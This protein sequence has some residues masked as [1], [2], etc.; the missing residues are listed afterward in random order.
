MSFDKLLLRISPESLRPT[1]IALK[2]TLT[3]P[4]ILCP[5]AGAFILKWTNDYRILF[6]VSTVL[7]C[8]SLPI[9]LGLPSRYDLDTKGNDNER[10]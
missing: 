1:Y 4:I 7:C 2:G 10:F 8:A 9:M 3:F 6:G 5:L